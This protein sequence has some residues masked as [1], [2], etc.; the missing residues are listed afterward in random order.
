M[1]KILSNICDCGNCNE[2]CYTIDKHGMFWSLCGDC[3]WWY[4]NY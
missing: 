1:L 3:G 2:M 4:L